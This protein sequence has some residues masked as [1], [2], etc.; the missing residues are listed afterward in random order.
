MIFNAWHR[1]KKTP[2]TADLTQKKSMQKH[3][4]YVNTHSHKYNKVFKN[5]ET[6]TND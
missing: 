4:K 5:Q 1:T 6:H 2:T 3:T